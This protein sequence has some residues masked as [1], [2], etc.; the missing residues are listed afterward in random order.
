MDNK[1]NNGR[2]FMKSDFGEHSF[3]SD[4]QKGISQPPLEK[5]YDSEEKLIDLP[6][7]EDFEIGE[8][9]FIELIENRK[10]LRNYADKPLTLKELSFLLWAT[11]GVKKVI[12]NGYAS[13]RT[14]PSAGARHPYETYLIVNRVKEL[15]K[16]VYRYLPFENK[17]LHCFSEDDTDEKLNKA[18]LGQKFTV[19]SAVVF[20]WTAIPY[21]SEW[22]YSVT[23]HK[24]MLLDAGHICQ[25]LYLACEMIDCGTCAI[26]AYDQNCMDDLLKID[27]KDEYVVYLS[28]VGKK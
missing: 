1:I 2:D 13:Y 23:S 10:S 7:I 28:P 8:V 24:P 14:V 9:N 25:N 21:R 12:R 20:V 15:E 26:A 3:K 6:N 22:R 27:G 16:G 18:T 17:L 4:Q 19:R 11:Q 5:N